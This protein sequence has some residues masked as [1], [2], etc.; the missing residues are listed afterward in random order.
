MLKQKVIRDMA[1]RGRRKIDKGSQVEM[2][3][4]GSTFRSSEVNKKRQD[5]SCCLLCTS[6]SCRFALKPTDALRRA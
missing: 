5:V 3:D 4:G 6:L 2:P 1:V